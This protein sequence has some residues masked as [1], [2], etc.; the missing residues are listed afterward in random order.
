MAIVGVGVDV[1][2]IARI[3]RAID[4]WDRRFLDR[5]YTA[6]EQRLCLQR[7]VPYACLAVRFAAK[8]AF[9][10]ALGTGIGGT[11]R[12]KDLEVQQSP[13]GAPTLLLAPSLR[14]RLGSVRVHLSLSH[15]REYAVA[16]VILEDVK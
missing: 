12:W 5:I 9:S 11:V 2:E 7:Q 14:E 4:Q 10:K 15:S 6:A 3:A 8:E 16:V 1:I 13:A